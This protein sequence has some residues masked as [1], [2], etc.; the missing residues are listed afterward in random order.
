[1]SLPKKSDPRLDKYKSKPAEPRPAPPTKVI[2][3]SLDSP[4]P[5]PPLENAVNFSPVEVMKFDTEEAEEEV[6][7]KFARQEEGEE[8]GMAPSTLRSEQTRAKQQHPD[9]GTNSVSDLV[10]FES[11]D[12]KSTL[13]F[14]KQKTEEEASESNPAGTE[15]KAPRTPPLT[16]DQ[17]V[18]EIQEEP[19]EDSHKNSE[20]P[21][22]PAENLE[23]HPQEVRASEVEVPVTQPAHV[24]SPPL[25]PEQSDSEPRFVARKPQPPSMPQP[26][27]YET[28]EEFL[29]SLKAPEPKVPPAPTKKIS[30]PVPPPPLKPPTEVK[31]DPKA[32]LKNKAAALEKA[33]LE[34]KEKQ[35]KQEL[36]ELKRKAKEK[37]MQLKK[38]IAAMKIQSVFHKHVM[39]KRLHEIALEAVEARRVRENAARKIVDA[40]IKWG[41][42]KKKED[43][44]K[45]YMN[46][47]A[48]LI[49]E[50]YR[51]YRARKKRLEEVK[52]Q[53]EARRQQ[54]Q[55]RKA[56]IARPKPVQEK[57]ESPPPAPAG[58]NEAAA[59]AENIL[60]SP[61]KAPEHQSVSSEHNEDENIEEEDISEA[62]ITA[63]PQQKAIPEAFMKK[64]AVAT[65][66]LP[67]DR[68]IKSLGQKGYDIEAAMAMD[69][70]AA[71][72]ATP[73]KKIL[74]KK[75]QFLKRKEV[76]DPRKA[77]EAS[78]KTSGPAA[79]PTKKTEEKEEEAPKKEASKRPHPQKVEASPPKEVQICEKN[80]EA[81][82]EG[83]EVPRTPVRRKN[84]EDSKASPKAGEGENRGSSEMRG[85]PGSEVLDENGQ[86]KARRD[87]LKRRSKKVEAKKLN[88]EKV[89]RRIDCWNPKQKE[90]QQQKSAEKK[91]AREMVMPAH[92]KKHAQMQR[93]RTGYLKKP[94]YFEEQK[95]GARGNV[96]EKAGPRKSRRPVQRKIVERAEPVEDPTNR[97]PVEELNQIFIQYHGEGQGKLFADFVGNGFGKYDDKK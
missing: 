14:I 43:L 44:L 7:K 82:K 61:I 81:A 86:P 26:Q 34:A 36:D 48:S 53:R 65:S 16:D 38:K 92:R 23:S 68:P 79:E 30:N 25:S 29:A 62:K 6:A 66:G 45:R 37:E 96:K 67:D 2:G 69:P 15:P 8:E 12:E 76:Y 39:K 20:K 55:Q 84:T 58:P 3:V 74:P 64:P 87:F 93:A 91:S 97:L 56:A 22:V 80:E 49:Q 63:M 41:E 35:K 70:A 50:R 21:P 60:P 78:K 17:R 24:E 18:E 83:K 19:G 31:P 90:Q 71:K 57:R 51:K 42:R 72:P 40:M 1:M 9:E 47:C 88:W 13:R 95:S 28:Y 94:E 77:I 89:P 11:L 73:P 27:I 52:R 59:E 33:R 85:E 4:G 32:E 54:Q 5:Q 46:H 75:K 10:N